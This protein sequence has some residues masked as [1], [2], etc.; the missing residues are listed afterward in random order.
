MSLSDCFFFEIS[1]SKSFLYRGCEKNLSF[2][3]CFAHISASIHRS[4]KCIEVEIYAKPTFK[5]YVFLTPFIL[6]QNIPLDTNLFIQIC[7]EL[8][9]PEIISIYL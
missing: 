8:L 1:G 6:T 3:L 4:V 9:G 7:L 5:T 2:N